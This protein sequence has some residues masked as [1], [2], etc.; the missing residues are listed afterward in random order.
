MVFHRESWRGE[1]GKIAWAALDFKDASALAALEMM[2]MA[3]AG[4]LIARAFAGQHDRS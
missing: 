1:A 2:M 4:G 3:V